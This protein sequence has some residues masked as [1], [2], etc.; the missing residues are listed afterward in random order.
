MTHYKGISEN[1]DALRFCHVLT[2]L[3]NLGSRSTSSLGRQ[4][5]ALGTWRIESSGLTARCIDYHVIRLAVDIK[6]RNL[7]YFCNL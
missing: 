7:E 4:T 2:V 1:L 5:Y 3:D 6:W